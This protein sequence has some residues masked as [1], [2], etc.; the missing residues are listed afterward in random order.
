MSH[1]RLLTFVLAGFVVLVMVRWVAERT[2]LPSAALLTLAGIGYSLLP[3]QNVVL[4]PEFVLTYLIPPLLY[5]AAL[6]SSLLAIRRYLVTVIGLSVLLVLITALTI[7]AGFAWF[8]GGATL[9]AGVTIGAAVAPHDPGVALGVARRSGLP[10]RLVTVIQGEGLLN[11]ATA[12]TLL[13]VAITAAAGHGFSGPAALGR[14]LL[15]AAGG[16]VAGALVAYG[17]RRLR[18]LA[19]DPLTANAISLATPF[20]AYL[21][22][23]WAGVSGVLAVVVT[24]LIV[25]HD[26]P[27]WASGASRLQTSAV[28]RL[29]DFLLEGMVFLLIGQQLPAILR[30]LRQYDAAVILP[31]VAVTVGVVLV[32]RPLWLLATHTL[33]ARLGWRS[34]ALTGR[35]VIALSWTGTRGVISLAAVLAVPLTTVDGS[36]FP[37][38]DLLVFCTL[39]AVLVT[40]LGQGLTLAPLVRLLGLHA[41]PDDQAALRNEAR[42]A[43]VHAAL[44]RLGELGAQEPELDPRQIAQMR[45]ALQVRLRRYEGRIE[46]LRTAGAEIEGHT[47]GY[48]TRAWLRHVT[49]DAQREELLRWRDAGRL[50]DAGLRVLERELD[51]EERMLPPG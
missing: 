49:I 43:S 20:A 26:A 11:D 7:G 16:I 9:A 44:I 48:E 36:P 24:G 18:H 13:S 32:S 28:W 25:G 6:D 8:V 19:R 4:N 22:A 14:L 17:V 39:T 47:E 41:S 37:L 29:V 15:A 50:P 34:G 45:E 1:E 38:R 12:L 35:E 27:R 21:L 23:E 51:H 40:L 2:G 10:V 30:D 42:S 46:S 31:A 3:G 33:P 5:S